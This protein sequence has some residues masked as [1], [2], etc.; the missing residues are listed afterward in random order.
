[1]PPHT[2][3]LPGG[4]I[5]GEPPVGGCR[6]WSVWDEE[7]AYRA[8]ICEMP[9]GNC[10]EI[11]WNGEGP[12]RFPGWGIA[13]DHIRGRLEGRFDWPTAKA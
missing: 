11:W 2:V 13:V 8:R 7:D 1:M 6:R 9:S 3:P 4:R 5:T 12:L 10:Y